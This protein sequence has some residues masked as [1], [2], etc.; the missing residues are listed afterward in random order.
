MIS[1]QKSCCNNFW[2]MIQHGKAIIYSIR[3]WHN[4][5]SLRILYVPNQSI[6]FMTEVKNR[7]KT[8]KQEK[9]V[10]VYISYSSLTKRC[11]P[12]LIWK[13]STLQ[14]LLSSKTAFSIVELLYVYQ[15][16]D[17]SRIRQHHD[18]VMYYIPWST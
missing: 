15:C 10:T 6:I 4:V 3:I 11:F 13:Y 16:K 14:H 1:T 5:L 12:S 9:E 17:L 8:W 2:C 7:V 18:D